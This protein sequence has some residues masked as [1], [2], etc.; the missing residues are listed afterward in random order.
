MPILRLAWHSFYCYRA[1][2]LKTISLNGVS[3]DGGQ[4]HQRLRRCRLY[5]FIL[6]CKRLLVMPSCS[7]ARAWT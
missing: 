1:I 3:V 6:Y 7:A 4:G 2:E 5:F